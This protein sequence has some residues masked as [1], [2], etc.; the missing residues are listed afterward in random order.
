[1]RSS[2]SV[3]Q[4][5][6][7]SLTVLITIS[8]TVI[9]TILDLYGVHCWVVC[10]SHTIFSHCQKFPFDFIIETPSSASILWK[11]LRSVFT[12]LLRFHISLRNELFP[13]IVRNIARV[14]VEEFSNGNGANGKNG[15]GLSVFL[16]EIF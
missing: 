5:D 12:L 8:F 7:V 10:Q 13:G 15:V 9:T 16:F 4:V 6:L 1:M 14:E 2:W 11:E 3:V